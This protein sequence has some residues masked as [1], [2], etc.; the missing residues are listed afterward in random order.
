MTGSIPPPN[1]LSYEGQVVVPFISRTFAPETTFNKFPVPTIWINTLS[2]TAYILVSKSL[3]VAVWATVGG[4]PGALNTITT[5]DSVVVT[6]SSGNINFLNGIGMAIT[7][8]GANI[9]FTST[10]GGLSWTDVTGTAQDLAANNGYT[11][12]N[13]ALVTLTLPATCA[14]GSVISVVGKG[15]GG[16]AIA[17]RAG[18][19]I[20]FGS[21]ST[22]I[23]VTGALSSTNRRDVVTLLCVA[24]DTDFEV[25]NSIGNIIH[26]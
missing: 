22:T 5:P 2:D 16:W 15:A 13:G 8:S 25:L 6:P 4:S 11:A 1:P 18:Q 17:Q 12:N 24:A 14:Y 19:Q 10:G 21:A 20:F 23:G 9:T 26:V 3:G 7:G